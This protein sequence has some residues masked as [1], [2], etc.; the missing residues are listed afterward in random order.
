MPLRDAQRY[1][2]L[3]ERDGR[4]FARLEEASLFDM[5]WIQYRV[6][7]LTSSDADR[8]LLYSQRFWLEGPLPTFPRRDGRL[9]QA[10]QR[11]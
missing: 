6:V 1:V 3:V 5:F 8:A 4:V 10:R 2:W 7:D 9:V 11:V